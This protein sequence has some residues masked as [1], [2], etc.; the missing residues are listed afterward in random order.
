M[1][2][3]TFGMVCDTLG[4]AVAKVYTALRAAIPAR[5]RVAVCVWPSNGAAADV[6]NASFE[7]GS[8]VPGVVGAMYTF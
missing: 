3:P 4:S 1:G 6:V 5:Q 8:S 2:R 7:A